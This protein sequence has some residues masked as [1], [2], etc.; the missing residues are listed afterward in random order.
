LELVLGDKNRL[1]KVLHDGEHV[2]FTT[3]SSHN[4]RNKAAIAT[5]ATLI[6]MHMQHVQSL[7]N[8]I[9]PVFLQAVISGEDSIDDEQWLRQFNPPLADCLLHWPK[10]HIG[11]LEANIVRDA[12]LADHCM[13]ITVRNYIWTLA[14]ILIFK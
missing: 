1:W 4:Q 6:A 12:L 13:D 3:I 8:N 9:S 2:L 7:P 14:H 5:S 10:D 11:P